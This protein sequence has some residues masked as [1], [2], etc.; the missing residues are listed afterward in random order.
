MS[1]TVLFKQFSLACVQFSSIRLIDRALSGATTL[2]QSAPGS[3][4]TEWL[5]R[6]PP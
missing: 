4:R 3:D 2:G 1:K 5:L 6:I